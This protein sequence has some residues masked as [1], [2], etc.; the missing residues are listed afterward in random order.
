MTIECVRCE[1]EFDTDREK[2]FSMASTW[3][4]SFCGKDN[5]ALRNRDTINNEKVESESEI[6][7]DTVGYSQKYDDKKVYIM[8][9]GEN[10]KVGISSN[11]KQRLSQFRTSNPEISLE[12]VYES[13]FGRGVEQ[14]VHSSL[15]EYEVRNE[16]FSVDVATGINR[17]AQISSFS[18]RLSERV[19]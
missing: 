4:C 19:V 7:T 6:I 8:S 5:S 12:F 14:S 13:R 15:S 18:S 16:W 1:N 10:I 11:P 17:V 9:S 3:R 2:T